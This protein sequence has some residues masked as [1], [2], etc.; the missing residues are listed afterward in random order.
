ME[1]DQSAN[2]VVINIDMHPTTRIPDVLNF[3]IATSSAI[4]WQETVASWTVML[5]Y[6]STN[7]ADCTR[8]LVII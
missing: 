4:N 2:G 5:M 1:Q 3:E 8:M 7:N 6:R